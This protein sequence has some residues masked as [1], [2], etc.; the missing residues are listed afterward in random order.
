MIRGVVRTI[1]RGVVRK[2]WGE[3]LLKNG[4]L[5]IYNQVPRVGLLELL[6][7]IIILLLDIKSSK[8]KIK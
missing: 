8:T 1:M 2:K 4:V 3:F 6:V 5:A 7:F